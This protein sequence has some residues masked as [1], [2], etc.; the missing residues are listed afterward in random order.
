EL[1][2]LRGRAEAAV[3]DPGARSRVFNA[4]DT[5]LCDLS[6]PVVLVIDDLQW[7]DPGTLLALRVL[8][9]SP[10]PARLLILATA[11]AAGGPGAVLRSVLADM[12]RDGTA[13]D[14]PLGGLALRDV[15]A[16]AAAWLGGQAD[17]ELA[18]A[19]HDRSGGNA[20]FAQELLRADVATG[21]E[22]P[23]SVGD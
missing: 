7:A 22:I 3:T 20:F 5:L 18:T 12:R 6:Q 2:R 19:V 13:E 15:S 17:P 23:E 16:L 8:L 14:I 9:R 11:R 4:L 10:R 21:S 1:D